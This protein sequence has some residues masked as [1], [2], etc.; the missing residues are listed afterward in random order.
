MNFGIAFGEKGGN[1]QRKN[2]LD[3]HTNVRFSQKCKEDHLIEPST[4]NE[5]NKTQIAGIQ[6]SDPDS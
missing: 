6:I 5:H 3:L 2:L 4:R 1:L